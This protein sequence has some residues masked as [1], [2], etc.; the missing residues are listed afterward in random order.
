[1]LLLHPISRPPGRR[2]F[3]FHYSLGVNYAGLTLGISCL[4]L[5]CACLDRDTHLY[6]LG[7]TIAANGLEVDWD[8]ELPTEIITYLA[9][10]CVKTETDIYHLLYR[11]N[12]RCLYHDLAEV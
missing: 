6:H 1:M 9:Y 4:D 11:A 2:E 10:L 3:K 8:L 12:P 7:M 5:E